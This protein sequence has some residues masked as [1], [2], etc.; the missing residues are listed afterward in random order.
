MAIYKIQKRESPFVQI[1]KHVF[2]NSKISWKAKGILGYLLSKPNDWKV[3]I[4]DLKNKSTD[5]K[6]ACRSALKELENNGYIIRKMERK[7]DGSYSQ[8][9]YHV[10]ERPRAI[11]S[12]KTTSSDSKANIRKSDN[13]INKPKATTQFS[14]S[15]K[16]A[17]G[18]SASVKSD[19]T[20]NIISTNKDNNKEPSSTYTDASTKSDFEQVISYWNKT[21]EEEVDLSDKQLVKAIKENLNTFTTDQLFKAME[22]RSKAA[23]YKNTKPE[24]RDDPHCF[25]PYKRTIRKDQKRLPEHS[26]K[27]APRIMTF[28]ERVKLESENNNQRSLEAGEKSSLKFEVLHDQKDDQGRPMHKYFP[29]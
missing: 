13:G 25:F 3:R 2:E 29:N 24:F 4:G 1:D 16:P 11:N 5:G 10:F 14:T 15:G 20:N 6:S 26:G 7:A 17:A 21:F 18:L 8:L 22:G 27:K 12:H 28:E 9:I 19:T 23:Y